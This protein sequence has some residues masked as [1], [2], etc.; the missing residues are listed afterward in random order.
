MLC[1]VQFYD[2]KLNYSI[3]KKLLIATDFSANANHAAEY[4]YFLAKQ[5]K[6]NVTLCNAFIVPAEIPQAGVVVWP[7]DDYD[8]ISK[9]IANELN[10]TKEKLEN[11]HTTGYR[12]AISMVNEAGGV[13]DVIC[14]VIN[15]HS[16][17]LTVLGTH[18]SDK[19]STFL[20]GDHSHKMINAATKPLLLIPPSAKIGPIKKIA[21]ATDFKHPQDDL[22][23]IYALIPFAKLLNAEI[24][25]THVLNDTH[26]SP[27]FQK[28]LDD[29]LLDLSNKA[30][31]PHIYYRIIRHG[32]AEHGLDW[33]CEHGRVD[34]LVM[35]HR[36]HNF[37]DGLLMGSYAQKMADHITIPL[38]VYPQ[39]NK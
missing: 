38:L 6:A 11:T 9:S 7:M 10:A 14:D 35:L 16:I 2:I 22:A 1:Y 25:L 21:Y 15:S 30:D 13:T 33:L 19:L 34:L 29:L 12:P 17:D 37:F 28:W 5:I 23:A 24:L 31:Y 3:M 20:F 27:S 18:G 8:T 26:H 39:T 4:G 36:H 32:D